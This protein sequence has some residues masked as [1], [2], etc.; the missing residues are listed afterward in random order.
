MLNRGDEDFGAIQKSHG[1]GGDGQ[2]KTSVFL[3][4]AIEL[5]FF[6]YRFFRV[7]SIQIIRLKYQWFFFQNICRYYVIILYVI[8]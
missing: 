4:R 2:W 8:S 5:I 7:L 3:L 1:S 6:A